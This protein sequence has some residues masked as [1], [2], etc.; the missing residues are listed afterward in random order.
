M[1]FEFMLNKHPQNPEL[2]N[3]SGALA[4]CLKK[5]V[6]HEKANFLHT[7]HRIASEDA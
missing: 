2:K 4:P 3:L 6:Q 5:Y 7:K 1:L